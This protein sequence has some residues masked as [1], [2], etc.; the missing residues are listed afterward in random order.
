WGELGLNRRPSDY[1]A[2]PLHVL[3]H[4]RPIVY[5]DIVRTTLPCDIGYRKSGGPLELLWHSLDEWLVLISK[6][7]DRNRK[8]PGSSS[9]SEIASLL[10][11]QCEVDHSGSTPKL[12]S[13]LD[14]QI[15]METDGEDVISMTANRLSA[16]I[17]AFYMCCS[18]QMPK[19]SVLG[20][21]LSAVISN[22]YIKKHHLT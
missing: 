17:Q 11:K 6:E 9:S 10:L 8:N 1:S 15:V 5:S 22:Q 18:C 14:P 4:S 13:L 2:N 7:L 3:S 16:V 21:H 12:P 19:G 20:L